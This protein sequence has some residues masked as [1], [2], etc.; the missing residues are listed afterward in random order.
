[1]KLAY[2][3]LVHISGYLG[4]HLFS[5]DGLKGGGKVFGNAVTIIRLGSFPPLL[6]DKDS[7]DKLSPQLFRFAFGAKAHPYALDIIA[8]DSLESWSESASNGIASNE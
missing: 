5:A 7:Y 2:A 4:Q 8:V 6:P 3:N 1:M